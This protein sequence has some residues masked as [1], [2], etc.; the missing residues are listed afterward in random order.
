M[1]LKHI[2]LGSAEKPSGELTPWLTPSYAGGL[3]QIFSPRALRRLA[4]NRIAIV[5][6]YLSVRTA[7]A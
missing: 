1:P 3:P 4:L 7:G 5:V 2:A 6:L